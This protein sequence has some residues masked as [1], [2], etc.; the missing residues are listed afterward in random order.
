MFVTLSPLLSD[1]ISE[2]VGARLGLSL[3]GHI[4]DR[5]RLDETLSALAPDIVFVGLRAGESDDIG[6]SVLRVVPAA[7]VLAI[8]SDGRNAYLHEMRP[9]RIKLSEC[10]HR[11]RARQTAVIV[12]A[13]GFK[14]LTHPILHPKADGRAA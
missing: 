11:I 8:S 3:V 6:L 14:S 12:A 10:D 5:D 13:R 2:S 1:I 7:R 4:Q 9:I